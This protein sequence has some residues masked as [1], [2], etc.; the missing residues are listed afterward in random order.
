MTPR[1]GTPENRDVFEAAGERG[2]SRGGGAAR[3]EHP[4][5]LGGALRV[6][7]GTVTEWL[8]Y[9]DRATPLRGTAPGTDFAAWRPPPRRARGTR[10]RD[11]G[12]RDAGLRGVQAG[13]ARSSSVRVRLVGGR[14]RRAVGGSRGAAV[15]GEDVTRHLSGRVAGHRRRFGRP[16]STGFA[17][18]AARKVREEVLT[19]PG[20]SAERTP[21]TVVGKSHSVSVVYF[22][23]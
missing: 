1:T 2:G 8:E 10:F 3:G 22:L 5:P 13:P 7:D 14:T 15:T 4:V 20:R 11:A 9:Y 18:D 6:A 19:G 17:R 16:P 12:L 23:A 21:R